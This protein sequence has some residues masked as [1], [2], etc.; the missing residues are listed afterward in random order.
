MFVGTFLTDN[1][2]FSAVSSACLNCH[3]S[4]NVTLESGRALVIMFALW[5]VGKTSL[6][7]VFEPNGNDERGKERQQR[8]IPHDIKRINPHIIHTVGLA[9]RTVAVF[10]ILELL[11]IHGV[12]PRRYAEQCVRSACS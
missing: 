1:Q 9:G 7:S 8:R 12:C 2:A 10:S 5:F 4:V 11:V 6:R 3:P